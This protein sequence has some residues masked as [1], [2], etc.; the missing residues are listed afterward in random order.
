MEK[1]QIMSTGCLGLH[2]LS[3]HGLPR[4][5]FLLHTFL[6]RFRRGCEKTCQ[7]RWG[8]SNSN[9]NPNWN[10]YK[11]GEWKDAFYE[12]WK[13]ASRRLNKLLTVLQPVSGVAEF[14]STSFS[15]QCL[16]SLG[17]TTLCYTMS[18]NP[19]LSLSRFFIFPKEGWRGM[20]VARKMQRLRE[21]WG[22]YQC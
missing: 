15:F 9:I 7:G 11:L 21:G 22:K 18:R 19:F 8:E 5:A 4:F 10:P 13:W 3:F 14:K 17:H 12:T 1:G 20:E 6:K 2:G 16:C